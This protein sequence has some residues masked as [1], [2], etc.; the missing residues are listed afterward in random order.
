MADVLEQDSAGPF[1]AGTVAIMGRPNVGKST[2]LNALLGTRIAAVSPRPQTSR[3]RLLGV[4]HGD[5]FQVALLDTPGW[6]SSP[7]VDALATRM[8]RDAREALALADLVLLMAE[9]PHRP[10]DVERKIVAELFGKEGGPASA[11]A[12]INKVDTVRKSALLPVIA[13]YAELYPFKEI[14]PISVLHDDGLSLLIQ[15]TV[16]WLPERA[17]LFPSDQLTDRSERFI[18]AELVREE[19]FKHFGDE[20]P[21]ATAVRIEEFREASLDHGGKDFIEAA[22]YVDRATQRG[23]LIGSGGA[24][25]KEVGASARPKI[26]NVLDRPVFL[27]LWVKVRPQ[28][29]RDEPF[30]RTLEEQ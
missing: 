2:L 16:A 4:L 23:I 26:E 21:Y 14:V 30:L 24:A 13:A 18:V 1:R 17:A 20:V 25:L 15:R 29:R 3:Y 19:L 12:V 11:L 27:A 6:P 28:W 5:A 9:P 22:I 10:G 7:R 8:M